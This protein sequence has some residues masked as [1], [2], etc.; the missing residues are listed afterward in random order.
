MK[1][2]IYEFESVLQENGGVSCKGINAAVNSLVEKYKEENALLLCPYISRRIGIAEW[3][4]RWDM[5]QRY[6]KSKQ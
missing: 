2:M 4:V 5:R 6:A 1:T 3:I